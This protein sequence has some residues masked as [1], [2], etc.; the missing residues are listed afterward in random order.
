ME[1]IKT[2]GDAYMCAG[3]LPHTNRTHA[4]DAVLA[5]LEIR[6]F[7][8]QTKEIRAKMDLPFWELRIGIHVCP[9]IAGVIG[10]KKFAY[11]I[12]GDTVNTA[13]RMESSA[14]I[15]SVNISSAVY[16]RVGD[17]F[18][19]TFRGNQIAK[20]KGAIP[21][22]C[23]NGIRSELLLNGVPGPAFTERYEALS[24]SA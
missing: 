7:V 12:W 13:S 1:K 8:D 4:V 21:M 10:E 16:E 9:V 23:V 2:I 15:G 22:Y 14:E 5:A 19:L 20:N 6:A 18:D 24:G 17:F 11:D 3:G